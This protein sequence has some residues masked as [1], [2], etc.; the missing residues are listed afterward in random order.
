VRL[1]SNARGSVRQCASVQ[2]CAAVQQCAYSQINSKHIRLHLYKFGIIQIIG[3]I[4]KQ[5]HVNTSI[6]LTSYTF[7]ENCFDSYKF[8]EIDV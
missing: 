8:K 5:N 1:S 2:Q 3:D 6:Q 4:I 7:K